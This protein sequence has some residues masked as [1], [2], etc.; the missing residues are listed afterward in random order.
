MKTNLLVNTHFSSIHTA[1]PHYAP[2]V[3][4]N[5]R[6]VNYAYDVRSTMLASWLYLPLLQL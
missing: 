5:R 4:V 6:I 1:C 3:G 2:H